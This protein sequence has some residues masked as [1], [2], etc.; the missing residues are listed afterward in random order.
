M[1]RI[2]QAFPLAVGLEMA[3]DEAASHHLSKVLRASLGEGL[4]IFN[5]EGGEYVANIIAI[6]KK[7]VTVKIESFTE[8]SLE[9]P[10]NLCLAQGVSRGDKM[11]FTIQK[12]VE[13]GVT[14]IMPLLTERTT[15]KFKEDRGQKRLEHWQSVIISACE[16]SGRTIIPKLFPLQSFKTWLPS[17]AA[18]QGFVLDPKSSQKISDISVQT[19]NTV[20]LLIGPEGGLSD[21]EIELSVQNRFQRLSL[22]PRILRTETAG[23]A[24]IST[25]QAKFG[26][27]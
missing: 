12:A 13:L 3:L 4:T 23:M 18:A 20:M 15:V 22:G 1:T 19:R 25:F 24:A 14:S 21:A 2:Y 5:G 17:V 8:I 26:D 27:F 11:D 10:L 7:R 16:Q 9:S 6:D